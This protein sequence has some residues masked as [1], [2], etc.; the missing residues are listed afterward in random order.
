MKKLIISAVI[1]LLIVGGVIAHQNKV[2]A[3]KSKILGVEAALEQSYYPT[4]I[5][6]L[7]IKL[8]HNRIERE[9]KQ[10]EINA[11]QETIDKLVEEKK[12]LSKDA[13]TLKNDMKEL[14]GL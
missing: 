9:N 11:L 14:L 1:T 2:N 13:D 12:I 10:L 6:W 8:W 3:L 4:E 5:E 7:E